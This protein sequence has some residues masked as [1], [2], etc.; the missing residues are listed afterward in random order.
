MGIVGAGTMGS[1][2]GQVFLGAGWKVKLCDV[3]K[4]VVSKGCEAIRARLE[5]LVSKGRLSHTDM[6]AQVS[7]LTACAD[8]DALGDCLLVVE[9]A[10]ERMEIKKAVFEGLSGKVAA[11]CILASNTSSLSITEIAAHA[12]RSERVIG[13][14]F[15]NPAP[16]MTLVEVIEGANTSVATTAAV[17]EIVQELGKTP[18]S[19]VESPGFLVNRLLV[20]MINDAAALLAEGVSDVTSIDT[21]MKLGCNHPIGPLALADMIGIDVILDVMTALHA[22]FGEDKYRVHPVIRKMVRAG[23]LG[24]KTERGFYDYAGGQTVAAR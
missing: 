20:P 14:H 12:D 17:I 6:D 4:D 21:A 22:E 16:V 19:V 3:S 9:A 11:D 8:Y 1:G 18:V 10:S 2:I 23:H 5:K 15:F 24:V 13:M 7:H